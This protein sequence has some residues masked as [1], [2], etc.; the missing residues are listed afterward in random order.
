MEPLPGRSSDRPAAAGKR[1]FVKANTDLNR[2]DEKIQKW[3]RLEMDLN[4]VANF[5]R[6]TVTG[7]TE[8]LEG[9]NWQPMTDVRLNSIVRTIRS[10][11]SKIA[12]PATVSQL[13]DSDFVEPVNPI[14]EYFNS[15]SWDQTDHISTLA[16]TLKTPSPEIM[17]KFLKK[18]L[19]AC[20]ANVFELGRCA[21]QT[22]FILAGPQ[23]VGK[24]TWVKNLIPDE[25]EAY[26]FEGGIDP[27]N[28]DS[29]IYTAQNF[30]I[31]LDDY[32]AAIT[33]NKVNELKGLLTKN[34]IQV[35]R[36]YARYSEHLPKIASFIASSNESEFLYDTTGNRRFLSF[37]IDS[38]DIQAL[39]NLN[40][41]Q[42]WAQAT[43]LYRSKFTYWLT[44]ED[45]KELQE[46][47]EQFEVA[48]PEYESLTKFFRR[49]EP[50]DPTEYLT[51]SEMK[52]ELEAAGFKQ[53]SLKKLGEACRKAGIQQISRRRN[54]QPVKCYAVSRDGS[55]LTEQND[56]HNKTIAE[57]DELPF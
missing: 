57:D 23:G 21:N 42:V 12:S 16:A 52:V 36:S 18:W 28:K 27:E 1:V 29:L 9:E 48:F 30:L 39:K 47:N 7:L 53:I 14:H 35:R 20:V 19:V 32:F 43:H 2:T 37:W 31:N 4:S 11:G 51:A 3:E 50:G 45:Q 17:R 8:M 26:Y 5:R 25:L 40:V 41:H 49:P 33:R 15:L 44:G 34:I 22:C 13:L 6:N 10:I 54:G 55:M 38:I 56:D 46:H 24:S